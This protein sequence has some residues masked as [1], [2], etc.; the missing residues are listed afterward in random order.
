MFPKIV[1]DT[2]GSSGKWTHL[3]L[4]PMRDTN[5][6]NLIK[7]LKL[8]SENLFDLIN[9][10]YRTFIID[11]LS[12]F[13]KAVS[14]LEP[15]AIVI[16]NGYVSKSVIVSSGSPYQRSIPNFSNQNDNS[17]RGSVRKSFEIRT[18]KFEST[19]ARTLSVKGRDYPLLV[20]SMLTGQRALDLG[21]RE[22]LV[23]HLKF[24]LGKD[25]RN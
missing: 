25:H 14:L 22:R 11:N 13:S 24:I 18:D 9:T 15:K 20:T 1:S 5:Q 17:D 12:V 6:S 21:S 4:L 8:N 19:G 2:I 7:N 10:K 23:W 3:D 16:V